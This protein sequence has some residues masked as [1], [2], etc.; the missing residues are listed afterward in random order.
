MLTAARVMTK[1]AWVEHMEISASRAM[2]F[3][4]LATVFKTVSGRF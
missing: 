1:A 3:F 2:I 4:T